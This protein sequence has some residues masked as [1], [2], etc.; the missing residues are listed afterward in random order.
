MKRPPGGSLLAF[1]IACLVAEGARA[2]VPRFAYVAGSRHLVVE[3]LNDRIAHFEWG[4]GDTLP[5]PSM[6]IPVTPQVDRTD[7]P[8][9]A[10]LERSGAFGGCWRPPRPGTRWTRRGC[11]S[12]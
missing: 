8:G 12:G 2:E 10:R 11:A 7:Y 5:D 9:P 3:V 4:S 1:L 6:S